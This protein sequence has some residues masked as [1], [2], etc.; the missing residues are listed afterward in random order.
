[1]VIYRDS[2][3]YQDLP[4]TKRYGSGRSPTDIMCAMEEMAYNRRMTG[5]HAA[6]IDNTTTITDSSFANLW[7]KRD[8]MLDVTFSPSTNSMQ[9]CPTA[10]KSKNFS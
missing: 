1:M 3:Q 2:D 6:P 9:G 8:N 4:L 7:E 10:R 5:S